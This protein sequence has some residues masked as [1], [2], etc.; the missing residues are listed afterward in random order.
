MKVLVPLNTLDHLNDYVEAGARE[1]YLGFYD[2]SWTE[3]FG[4][5]ADINRLTGFYKSANPNSFEEILELIPKIRSL[6]TSVYVTFNSSLYSEEQIQYIRHYF[7]KLKEVNIDGVIVSCMELVKLAKQLDVPC[8]ASTICGIYNSDIAIEYFNAGA[9]RLILPRDL[10]T[11][12]I[13]SIVNNV[14]DAE[15]EVFMMRNGCVFSDSN[16]LGL[17][18]LENCAICANLAGSVHDMYIRNSHESHRNQAQDN[19]R[20]YTEEFH[21]NTCGLC[22]IYDFVKAGIHAGKIVGRSDDWEYICKDI[23][24]VYENEKIA[25]KCTTREEY[26]KKMKYPEDKEMMCN[27]GL[28]CY[29]PELRFS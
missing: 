25:K 23:N 26:F 20:I 27:N 17:H 19:D 3:K 8:V 10:N 21:K 12:E 24:L 7:E 2:N 15:F 11:Q 4:H 1:F 6:N 22:S 9:K 18:R 29:Y 13:L 14:P 16:C 28:T 5:Y